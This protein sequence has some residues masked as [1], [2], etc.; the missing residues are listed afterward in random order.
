MRLSHES[1]QA[2]ET[3]TGTPH[4]DAALSL[5]APMDTHR[6]SDMGNLLSF[7]GGF[8]RGRQVFSPLW[9]PEL[10]IKMFGGRNV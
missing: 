6:H 2:P 5:D 3:G 7:A 8:P 9:L 10:L 1:C 4:S